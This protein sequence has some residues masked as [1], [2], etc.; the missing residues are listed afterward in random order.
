MIFQY[1]PNPAD[2]NRLQSHTRK[3][4]TANIMIKYLVIE[5]IEHRLHLHL[6]PVGADYSSILSVG[7]Y[8]HHRHV[9]I[10]VHRVSGEVGYLQKWI[11]Y[12][13]DLTPGYHVL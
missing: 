8:A 2:I 7:E 11:Y 6:L 5:F 3:Y 9:R 12:Y 1:G 10:P 13:L 4:I